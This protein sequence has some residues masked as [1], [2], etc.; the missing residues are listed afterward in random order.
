[1]LEP[2]GRFRVNAGQGRPCWRDVVAGVHRLPH[3]L[4]AARC[5]HDDAGSFADASSDGEVS[6]RVASVQRD[7]HIEPLRA[8]LVDVLSDKLEALKTRFAGCF[9]TK[10]DQFW[11]QFDACDLGREAHLLGQKIVQ[12]EGQVALA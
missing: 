1:M 12:C 6:G 9:L 4:V 8:V 5:H 10:I 3:L 2:S 11:A 7:E